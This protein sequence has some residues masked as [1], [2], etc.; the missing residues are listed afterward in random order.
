MTDRTT[1]TFYWENLGPTHVDRLERLAADLAETH[2]IVALQDGEQS[3]VY[4]WASV[5]GTAYDTRTL[6]PADRRRG[7]LRDAWRLWRACRRTGARD[8][9]L[10]HYQEPHVLIAALLLRLSRVR[11]HAMIDSKFDD[12]PRRLPRELVKS[13]FLLPY[14]G[15][16][17]ASRRARDYLAFFGLPPDRIALGYDTL[18]VDRIEALAAAPPAP[19]GT[20]FA[21]RHFVVVA[22]HVAKKNIALA[23]D[24]YARWRAAGPAVARDLHLCGSGPLEGELHAQVDRLGLADHVHFHGFVQTDDVASILSRTLCLLLPSIEEQFGLVVI[25][26]QAMGV[27][28]LASTNAGACD[29]LIDTGLNGFLLDPREP[30]AWAATMALLSEDEACWHRAAAATRDSRYRGD[31]RHFTAGVRHLIEREKVR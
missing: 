5:A 25:E 16:L 29:T 28:V 27:P 9:F 4:A 30:D 6:F 21:N 20:P 14:R 26:A 2:R 3:R 17:T 10:C 1:L 13:L 18:S 15:A 7:P 19:D 22:R 12:Y 23:I 24:A 11:V 31:C 8:V